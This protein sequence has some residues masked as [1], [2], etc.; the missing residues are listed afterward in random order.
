MRYLSCKKNVKIYSLKGG[1]AADKSVIEE[2][3][4]NLGAWI[5]AHP[6][7]PMYKDRK[8]KPIVTSSKNKRK[9]AES[10]KALPTSNL[11][12]SIGLNSPMF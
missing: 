10:R 11:T 2:D 4:T 12:K 8:S 3:L 1:Q 5:L 6:L 9:I 7:K